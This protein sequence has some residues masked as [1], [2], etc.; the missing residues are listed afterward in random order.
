MQLVFKQLPILGSASVAAAEAAQCAAAQNRFWDYHDKLFTTPAGS[1][2]GWSP[3]QLKQFASDLGLDRAEFD[4]CLETRASLP[5][6]NQDVR[7]AQQLGVDSTPSFLLN[8][9]LFSGAEPYD[10]FEQLIEAALRAKGVS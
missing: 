1:P 10:V 4:R 9:Q 6:I 5:A 2:N 8:G 7:E 3:D